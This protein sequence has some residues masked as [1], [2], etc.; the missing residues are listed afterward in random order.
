MYKLYRER[1]EI[2]V[3]VREHVVFLTA[4]EMIE[5][6]FFTYIRFNCVHQNIRLESE[7]SVWTSLAYSLA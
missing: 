7:R 2:H 5:G 3:P 1:R 4:S 6:F